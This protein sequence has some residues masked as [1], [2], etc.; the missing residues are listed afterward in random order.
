MLAEGTENLVTLRDWVRWGASRF[1]EAGLCFGHGT[2]SPLDEALALVLHTLHLTHDVPSEFLDARLTAAEAEQVTRLI[3]RRID[4]RIPL[5]Y[6]THE[7]RF[8]GLSFFVNEN[9]LVPR[10]PIAELIETGFDPWLDP[11]QV[12]D[13]LD[14]CTGSGCIAIACAYAFPEANID[15][16]DISPSALEVARINV[17]RHDLEGRVSLIRSD[18]FDSLP[19]GRYDLMVSNPPYVSQSEM[20]NLPEEFSH[21]PGLGLEAG[22]DGLDVVRRILREAE[23]W[24]RPDGILVVEVGSSAE[25][26]MAGYPDVPFLWLD[27]E[28]GGDGVFLLTG[29][30][31]AEFRASLTGAG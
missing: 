8:A 15:A 22:E 29:A 16:T 24:L 21:E 25:A 23:D 14:L 27:F 4:E 13:V 11:E 5:A 6:L 3:R 2:D 17:D 20:D 28:R 1:A 18:V 19:K 26:L 12:T 30:Q 9:V 10:S 31:L 7:A